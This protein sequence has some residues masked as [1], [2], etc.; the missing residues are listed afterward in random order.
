MKMYT[1]GI[2]ST[3]FTLHNFSKWFRIHKC[4][5]QV[6]IPRVVQDW[7]KCYFHILALFVIHLSK[8]EITK[9][10]TR[11]M[12]TIFFLNYNQNLSLLHTHQ[13]K[14]SLQI[15]YYLFYRLF[16]EFEF[17]WKLNFY[18]IVKSRNEQILEQLD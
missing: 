9:T 10:W 14:C 2:V 17:L 6:A 11:M 1:F 8:T 18:S 13:I 7:M 15:E 3:Q 4:W 5:F 12:K 16:T